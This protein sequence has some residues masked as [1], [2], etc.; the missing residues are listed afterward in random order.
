[1]SPGS[2]TQYI[3]PTLKW[4]FDRYIAEI[5]VSKLHKAKSNGVRKSSG[6]FPGNVFTPGIFQPEAEFMNSQFR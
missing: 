2:E 3:V 6:T 1:L 4:I 5:G